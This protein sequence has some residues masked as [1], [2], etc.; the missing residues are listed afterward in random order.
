M[1]IVYCRIK[2]LAMET[3]RPGGAAIDGR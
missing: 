3:P 1:V 2:P